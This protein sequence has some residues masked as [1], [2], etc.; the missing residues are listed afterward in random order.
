[1]MRQSIGRLM[2][3][4]P[5]RSFSSAADVLI[6]NVRVVRPCEDTAVEA[7]DI[8][9]QDG[10]FAEIGPNLDASASAVV[11]DGKGMLAFPGCVFQA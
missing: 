9:I 10:K 6:K 5:A 1:M 7:V 2:Q 4:A 3:L 8:R 11:H